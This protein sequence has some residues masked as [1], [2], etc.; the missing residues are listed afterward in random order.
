MDKD[1]CTSR[2][3]CHK[4]GADHGFPDTGRRDEDTDS[5][6][7]ECPSSLLLDDSQLALETE[8]EP[9]ALLT[10]IIDDQ[11]TAGAAE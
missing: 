4:V 11:A 5:V 8:V 1:E 10:L 7:Q 9:L 2:P 3:R 6:F